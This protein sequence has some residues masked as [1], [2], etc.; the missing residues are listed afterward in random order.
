MTAIEVNDFTYT[1]PNCQSPALR[2]INLQI[3]SGQ[4]VAVIGANA[5]GKSTLCLALTGLI[6]SVFQGEMQGSITLLGMDTRHHSTADWGGRIGLAL[7]N[8][9]NQLSGICGSVYEEVAFGLENFG[10]PPDEMPQR[11]E[12]VLRQVG[13]YEQRDRSPF[14][15]SG[16]QQQRLALASVLALQPSLLVL[17]EPTSMLDPRGKQE[18]FVLVQSLARDGCTVV[19]AEHHLEWIAEHAARVI[20]LAEGSVILDGNPQQVL[21]SPLLVEKGI[22]WQRCTQAAAI[23]RKR[24][25]WSQSRPLPVILQEA[26]AGF[27]ECIAGKQTPNR[28]VSHSN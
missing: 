2:N 9:N 11:I 16:G 12:R 3:E 23:A 19:I 17:D 27:W 13:L 15:L 24:G 28:H 25:L 4:I 5:A 21:N 1:Y 20:A 22:G 26:E 7:Q 6:P 18:V 14:H 8:P 10:V